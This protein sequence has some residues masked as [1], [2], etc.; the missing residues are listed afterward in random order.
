MI[1]G[2]AGNR[3]EQLR[4]DRAGQHSIRINDQWRICFS[5]ALQALPTSRSRTTTESDKPTMATAHPP[6]HPG[7]ILLEEF[8]IPL[9]ISQYRLA[10]AIGVPPRRINEIVHGKR[11]ISPDTA[12]R[13]SRA[14][15]TSDR[16]WMNL[17]IRYD[18]DVQLEV[19][20]N[21]L[22]RLR[23]WSPEQGRA[24]A[25]AD[26]REVRSRTGLPAR[27]AEPLVRHAESVDKRLPPNVASARRLAEQQVRVDV[28]DR[29][30]W[31]QWSERLPEAIHM[32]RSIP[33]A[34]QAGQR[35]RGASRSRRMVGRL[36]GHPVGDVISAQLAQPC[37]QRLPVAAA[38]EQIEGVVVEGLGQQVERR[39]QMLA[40][41]L[42]VQ[43]SCIAGR[44]RRSYAETA[45]RRRRRRAPRARAEPRPQAAWRWAGPAP[46]AR[47]RPSPRPAQE[48]R[49]GRS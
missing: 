21:E 6:I 27:S 40:R 7:E 28:H 5:W 1:S 13:L 46:T 30:S 47:S 32:I 2:A 37:Q 45:A 31:G 43:G 34:G 20:R 17:Q 33:G 9:G 24:N 39:R 48:T 16:F 8:L 25:E 42:P 10:H 22:D 18:L 4:G 44:A 35:E 41:H 36:G 19:H 3:L 11:A 38:P 15:D 14:F 49:P 26:L 23:P 29:G 12:L